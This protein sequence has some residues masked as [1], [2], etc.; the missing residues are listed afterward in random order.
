MPTHPACLAAAAL[1]GLG[2]I[3][4]AADKVEVGKPAPDVALP[5]TQIDKVL[6]DQ[7]DAK[8]LR[9]HD[10]KGKTVVLYFFPRAM[11]AG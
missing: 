10:L 7:K 8:T 1:L 11:T 6:P 3:A 4:R 5:A 9:L 2:L